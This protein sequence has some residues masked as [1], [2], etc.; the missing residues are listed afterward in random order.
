MRMYASACKRMRFMPILYY[1]ILFYALIFF[2]CK[3]VSEIPT[4]DSKNKMIKFDFNI[5]ERQIN[6]TYKELKNPVWTANDY[7]ITIKYFIVAYEKYRGKPHYPI[8]CENLKSIMYKL[9]YADNDINGRQTNV[10]FWPEDY[11]S[12]I[13]DKY[14]NTKF[15]NNC[16]Y[17]IYH[18]LSDTI[19][20]NRFY[21]SCY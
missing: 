16:D 19:R 12:G 3:R 2:Y 1:T 11:K 15:N 18:F 5:L 14:F 4:R 8:K 6:K 20:N 7:Y 21:E 17:S 13:I 10:D 9:P